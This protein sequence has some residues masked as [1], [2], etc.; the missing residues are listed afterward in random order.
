MGIEPDAR[1]AQVP[2][3]TALTLVFVGGAIGTLV[4]AFLLIDLQHTDGEFSM[5]FAINV[6]GSFALGLLGGWLDTRMLTPRNQK[7]RAFV[8]TGLL[9]GFTSYS[10]LALLTALDLTWGAIAAVLSLIFGLAAAWFGLV[11]GRRFGERGAPPKHDD[12]GE[13][14][15]VA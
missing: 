6:A 4:R 5:L 8:G 1:S 9:G 15:D 10:T 12:S 7:L 3:F 13:R 11:L 14:G 2:F